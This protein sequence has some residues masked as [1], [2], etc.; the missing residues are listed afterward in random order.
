MNVLDPS[1]KLMELRTKLGEGGEGAVWASPRATNL[2][3]KT[4]LKTMPP[5]QADKLQ[6]M[7]SVA[8]STLLAAAAWP[9]RLV[10]NASRTPV[11]F[12]M[13]KLS[14][15]KPLHDLI[16]MKSRMKSFPN[17]NWQ[18]L[19]HAAVNLALAFDGLH[20]K[21]IVVGDVNSNNVVIQEDARVLF[22]DCDSFQIRTPT[23]TF[24]CEVGVP[25]YQPPELQAVPF[26]S[27]DRLPSHDAFGMAV[28]IFQL[29]FVGKHPFMGRLPNP[30][31]AAPTPGENI[32]QGN[33]FYDEQARRLGLQPPPA[34]L[35]VGAVTPAVAELFER[36]FRGRPEERP[37]AQ[38]WT[39]ALAELERAIT[40]CKIYAAHRYLTRTPC[41]WCAI[42][43]HTKIVYFAAPAL[44]T[45]SGDVDDSIWSTFP[46]AEVERLWRE[47]ATI[48]IPNVA[49]EQI[50]P[51]R[52]APAPVGDSL[53]KKGITFVAVLGTLVVCALIIWLIPQSRPYDFYDA[54]LVASFWLFGRPSGGAELTIRRS[55]L[56]DARRAFDRAEADWKKLCE[57]S[58][59]QS[60]RERLATARGSMVKQRSAYDVEIAQVR[61][62]GL[63]QAK[64][65][66]L[67][68]KFIRD[69]KIKGI[70]PQLT[71]RLA[72][73]NIE[74]ALDIDA[75]VHSVSGI[76]EQKAIALFAWRTVAE[77]LFRFEPKMIESLVRDVKSK[78]VQQRKQGRNALMGGANV[79]REVSAQVEAR[80]PAIR[81]KAIQERRLLD[82]AQADVRPFTPLIYR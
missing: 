22:I 9:T 23:R 7:T 11:G 62:A 12:E 50:N 43:L 69:A 44:V 79:L 52:V 5:V 68:A 17:A 32:A 24:R 40:T 45:L 49:F 47:I 37:L 74:T 19:V 8:D 41:P 36:A 30:G 38:E 10:Y 4:Y 82:Q 6:A 64:R 75:R 78:Y 39:I 3:I 14:G 20:R 51:V 71:A 66:Y 81:A 26:G 16:G 54:I 1:G 80:A 18:W 65:Q 42:E 34:S 53:R 48:A 46:N 70:G 56:R 61:L 60:Q 35:S 77:Q 57:G 58:E 27:V 2:A 31:S 33:Y 67:D 13:P 63:E 29:L 76:G 59:F 25:E 72:A 73:W 28:M 21:N 15:Q 55:K